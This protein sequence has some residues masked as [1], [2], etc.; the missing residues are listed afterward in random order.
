M[1]MPKL[2]DLHLVALKNRQSEVVPKALRNN[3]RRPSG[4]KSLEPE[5]FE[6]FLKV[7]VCVPCK[8]MFTQ[9]AF[10]KVVEKLVW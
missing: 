9:K 4:W 7:Q 1:S 3:T 2:G 10:T 8:G 5:T 6:L